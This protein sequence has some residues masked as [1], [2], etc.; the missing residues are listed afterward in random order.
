ML[1][2]D[3]YMASTGQITLIKMAL[4]VEDFSHQDNILKYIE[5]E[6]E[7]SLNMYT[8]YVSTTREF[9]SYYNNV[10]VEETLTKKEKDEGK[11]PLGYFI[12]S[13]SYEFVRADCDGVDAFINGDITVY[14]SIITRG[15]G[16]AEACELSAYFKSNE[17]NSVLIFDH[18]DDTEIILMDDGVSK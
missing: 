9:I 14:G 3:I 4:N 5:L 16:E 10:R 13:R 12:A 6:D 7:E 11:I 1:D 15:R 8:K 18:A 2:K 17:L